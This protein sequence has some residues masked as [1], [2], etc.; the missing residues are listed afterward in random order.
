MTDFHIDYESRSCVDLDQNG[1]DRYATDPTTQ[2]ILAAYAEGDHTPRL[3]QPH[4]DPKM[5]GELR[6]ALEDPWVVVHAWNASFERAISKF[7]LKI[8]KP[9]QEWRD[10]M[11]NARCLSL[12]G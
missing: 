9:I 6:E 10:P 8:D 7:V 3:W 5:P 1:L 11:V 12:P 2:V 4:L